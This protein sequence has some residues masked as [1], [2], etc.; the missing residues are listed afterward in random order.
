MVRPFALA[1][2]H[3]DEKDRQPLRLL[4]DLVQRRRAAEQDH[5]VGMLGPRDPDLLAVDPVDVA[6]PTCGGAQ[7]AGIGAAGRL[8]DAEGLQAQRPLGDLR[9]IGLL[10]G[11][12]AM[13]QKRAHRV[14]LRVTGAGIA[15]LAVDFFEDHRGGRKR[16]S[17]S[18]ELFRDQRRKK[19]GLGQRLH[20]IGRIG[21]ALVQFAPVAARE[22][23]A[24][25]S[26]RFA[27][28]VMG[29]D[30]GHAALL[31]SGQHSVRRG[32]RQTGRAMEAIA[33]S[34]GGRGERPRTGFAVTVLTEQAESNSQGLRASP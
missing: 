30:R 23:L 33:V 7:R 6:V 34:Y 32:N 2:A 19:A 21:A 11:V 22:I 26:H 8:G 18:A 10:L 9:Q 16:Q 4:L 12:R 24:E 27:D 13:P 5:Q 28:L 25:P 20:E 3:V 29:V 17:R 31:C 15:A 1:S 14:H